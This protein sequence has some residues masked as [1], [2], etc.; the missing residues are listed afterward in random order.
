MDELALR[1]ERLTPFYHTNEVTW[2]FDLVQGCRTEEIPER[3]LGDKS[4]HSDAPDAEMD[5][6]AAERIAPHRKSRK[7]GNKTQHGRKLRRYPR[8]RQV[9]R[10]F[11]RLQNFRRLGAC[12]NKTCS[13]VTALTK[14]T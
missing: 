5:D 6:C 10:F 3:V 1:N 2:A 9:E 13:W 8:R 4:Y 12:R 11:A 7:P 14:Q